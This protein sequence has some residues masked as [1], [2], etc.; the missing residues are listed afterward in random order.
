MPVVCHDV[1]RFSCR[2]QQRRRRRRRRYIRA[3][4]QQLM[5]YGSGTCQKRIV[6]SSRSHGTQRRYKFWPELVQ[7]RI[8]VQSGMSRRRHVHA[9]R[10]YFWWFLAKV[11][12][13]VL[14]VL[15]ASICQKA[16]KLWFF[17]MFRII[18]F[19]QIKSKELK[20]KT[21]RFVNNRRSCSRQCTLPTSRDWTRS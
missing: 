15:Q 20:T 3:A 6:H 17:G 13:V 9:K 12:A 11:N 2:V 21:V 18:I 10:R 1:R 16:R 7:R 8:F 19:R 4:Q 14:F 5:V